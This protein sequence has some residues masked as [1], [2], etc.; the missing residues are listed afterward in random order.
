MLKAN[1]SKYHAGS[2]N[3]YAGKI[4]LKSPHALRRNSR[5]ARTHSKKQ[6]AQI[7]R[8]IDRLGFNVPVLVDADCVLLAGHGRVE[9]AK[10]LKLPEIPVIRIDHLSEA[11]K[12]AFVLA[13]IRP[14]TDHDRNAADVG[15][16]PKPEVSTLLSS[17]HS[18]SDQGLDRRHLRM[19]C[20][21]HDVEAATRHRHFR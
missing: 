16:V 4:E 14:T 19:A 9:A 5:N 6:I 12:R 2:Q 10:L 11:G 20:P 8:S 17:F 21:V 13:D 15:Y 1:Q 3:K 18:P 7:A